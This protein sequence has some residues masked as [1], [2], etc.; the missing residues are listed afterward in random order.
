[1]FRQAIITVTS[2]SMGLCP[3]AWAE[4][5]LLALDVGAGGGAQSPP[6]PCHRERGAA[7]G[8]WTVAAGLQRGDVTVAVDHRKKPHLLL[9]RFFPRGLAAPLNPDTIEGGGK[10]H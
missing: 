2:I 8:V 5:A 9:F 6:P 4:Q 7:F 3:A 1:M 10:C